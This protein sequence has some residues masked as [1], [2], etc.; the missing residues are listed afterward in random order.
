M[1]ELDKTNLN[2]T[3]NTSQRTVEERRLG[4]SKSDQSTKFKKP[5]R[6]QATS[7]NSGSGNFQKMV[8]EFTRIP[9]LGESPMSGGDSY[10]WGKMQLLNELIQGREL[11][12]Q[13][14]HQ[15]H[16]AVSS[17]SSSSHDQTQ[18]NAHPPDPGL[19]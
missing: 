3:I 1:P 11:T 17:S 8:E 9:S 13:L 2:K 10:D 16:L 12:K 15:H 18:K 14:E 5:A 6:V 19:I 7:I 4:V